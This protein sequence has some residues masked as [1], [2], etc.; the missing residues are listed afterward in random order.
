MAQ[1]CW[2]VGQEKVEKIL[3]LQV[4]VVHV[5]E[6]VM[7]KVLLQGGGLHLEVPLQQDTDTGKF[8]VLQHCH[9]EKE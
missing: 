7:W 3:P 8:L 9:C 1:E 6:Q 4:L 5:E 2:G